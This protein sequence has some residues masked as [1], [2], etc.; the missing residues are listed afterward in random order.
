MASAKKSIRTYTESSKKKLA[1]QILVRDLTERHPLDFN[2]DP[3][4]YEMLGFGDWRPG[5]EMIVTVAE[6][7]LFGDD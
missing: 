6:R 5:N 3:Y 4:D 2:L 7:I 1:F